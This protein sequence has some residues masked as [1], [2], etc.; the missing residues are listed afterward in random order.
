MSDIFISY[1]SADRQ[2]ARLLADALSSQGW[3]VWWDRTIPP[4]KE[5]DQVIEEALDSAKC[6]V[7]LWSKTSIG[8][9]WVKTEAAEAMRRKILVPALIEAT[10]IPL[11]FRRLQ[12]ADLSQWQGEPSDPELEKLFRSIQANIGSVG[13]A[14]VET[15]PLSQ[16]P[17]IPPRR[18][19]P[20]PAGDS[21]GEIFSTRPHS[22]SLLLSVGGAVVI[23]ALVAGYLVYAERTKRVEFEQRMAREREEQVERDRRAQEQ[24]AREAA[25]RRAEE[26]RRAAE[27]ATQTKTARE[28]PAGQVE[29]PGG[30]PYS[31]N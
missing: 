26:E 18:P 13:E 27:R 4:G 25:L 11:E 20:T 23:V 1:A 19:E 31:R 28:R 29:K 30:Y 8:S 21:S 24:A 17:P 2:R 7:V 5:F 16:L 10:K 9:S 3:S 22:K 6:V 15:K 12:A 14:V